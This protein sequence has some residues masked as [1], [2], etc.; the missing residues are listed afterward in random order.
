[1]KDR[2]SLRTILLCQQNN[3]IMFVKVFTH[4]KMYS[5]MNCIGN[6]NWFGVMGRGYGG[7]SPKWGIMFGGE[8]RP[9]V[10]KCGVGGIVPQKSVMSYMDGP[11]G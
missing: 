5:E 8:F 1:V 7:G 10:T 2:T 3:K 9:T 6:R 11:I 4:C